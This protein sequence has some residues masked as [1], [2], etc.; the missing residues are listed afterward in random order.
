MT[1]LEFIAK[2]GNVAEKMMGSNE[3]LALLETAREE[4]PFILKTAMDPTTLINQAG[5]A[6]GWAECV[7]WFKTAHKLPEKKP[8][9]EHT[10][11]YKDPNA[12]QSK[13]QPPENKKP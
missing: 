3:F 2:Y 6:S 12:E 11:S 5:A 8:E 9:K 4:N 10:G 13:L 7:K 1:K